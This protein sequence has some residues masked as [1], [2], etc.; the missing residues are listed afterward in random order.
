MP[1]FRFFPSQ[2]G[3]SEAF[4]AFVPEVVGPLEMEFL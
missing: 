2:I 4:C 1:Q 3:I